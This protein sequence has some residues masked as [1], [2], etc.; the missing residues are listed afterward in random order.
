MFFF[1]PFFLLHTGIFLRTRSHFFLIIESYTFFCFLSF[2]L[3][4]FL[5][6][7]FFFVSLWRALHFLGLE[8]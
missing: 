5:R 7:H 3:Y 4:I 6:S 8:R 2:L 1:L